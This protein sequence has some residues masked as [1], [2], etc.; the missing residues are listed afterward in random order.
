MDT[1]KLAKVLTVSILLIVLCLPFG[2]VPLVYSIMAIVNRNDSEVMVTNL[3][4]A[5]KW[6]KIC[7]IS[8]I[9]LYVILIAIFIYL[10]Q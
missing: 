6:L 9:V 8:M 1:N 4:K 7:G 3:N 2:I 5:V 10:M